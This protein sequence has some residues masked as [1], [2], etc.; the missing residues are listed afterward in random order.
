MYLKIVLLFMFV[1]SSLTMTSCGHETALP[2]NLTQVYGP[3]NPIECGD[4]IGIGEDHSQSITNYQELNIWAITVS[5]SLSKPC[6]VIFLHE[7]TTDDAGYKIA[8][9]NFPIVE[10]WDL[11]T[12]QLKEYDALYKTVMS[13]V[14]D[15]ESQHNK[16]Q[17]ARFIKFNQQREDSLREKIESTK[18]QY[19]K[20]LIFVIGGYFHFRYPG[21]EIDPIELFRISYQGPYKNNNDLFTRIYRMDQ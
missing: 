5:Q 3:T 11:T 19:G 4:V 7:N 14:F 17:I 20:P 13:N 12:Q 21:Q 9:K 15:H 10:S 8:A 6:S 1:I 2:R 16:K 18:R